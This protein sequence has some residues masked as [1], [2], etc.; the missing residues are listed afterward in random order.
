MLFELGL[1]A[2]DSLGEVFV[3][4]LEVDDGVVV[5]GEARRFHAAWDGLPAV[6]EEDGHV[7]DASSS[8]RQFGQYQGA[9]VFTGFGLRFRHLAQR[10]RFSLKAVFGRTFLPVLG[11]FLA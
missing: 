4:R 1:G 11:M 10:N 2:S 8:L 5:M 9:G 3:R 6:E 7:V